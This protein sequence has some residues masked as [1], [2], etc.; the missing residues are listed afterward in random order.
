ML[1]RRIRRSG[2]VQPPRGAAVG[3]VVRALGIR[4]HLLGETAQGQAQGL[5]PLAEHP[6]LHLGHCLQRPGRGAA[7]GHESL[8]RGLLHGLPRLGMGGGP[9]QRAQRPRHLRDPQVRGQ[10]RPCL[11]P[12]LRHARHHGHIHIP[13]RPEPERAAHPRHRHGGRLS[14]AVQPQPQRMRRRGNP[15]V[16]A[17]FLARAERGAPGGTIAAAKASFCPRPE[18]TAAQVAGAWDS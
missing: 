15:G 18:L 4:R 7:A 2:E 3:A 5:D 12:R 9:Q 6:A 16:R 17:S 8:P 1:C 14:S 11:R 13:L 10:H